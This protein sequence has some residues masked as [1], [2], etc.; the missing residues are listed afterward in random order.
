MSKENTRE[1]KLKYIFAQNPNDK[2]L[3]VTSDDQAF[4]NRSD[5]VNHAKTLQDKDVKLE[6][7]E[8]YVKPLSV[9]DE[10]ASEPVTDAKSEAKKER[11]A[12]FARHEE[13]FKQKPAAN[14]STEKLKSKIEAE[15]ARLAEVAAKDAG[16]TEGEQSG[17]E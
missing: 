4:R 12:L 11:D 16:S 14:A 17:E 9:N 5:A 2:E 15:E 1:R 13:L 6:K 8:D 3:H 7:R 10:K